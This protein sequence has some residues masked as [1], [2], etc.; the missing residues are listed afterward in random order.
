MVQCWWKPDTLHLL[1][2]VLFL[3]Y[4]T[5]ILVVKD[6]HFSHNYQPLNA[7]TR[8]VDTLL[9]WRLQHT[10]TFPVGKSTGV[11]D[12]STLSTSTEKFQKYNMRYERRSESIDF[13]QQNRSLGTSCNVAQSEC[14]SSEIQLLNW[15][16]QHGIHIHIMEHRTYVWIFNNSWFCLM[17]VRVLLRILSYVLSEPVSVSRRANLKLASSEPSSIPGKKEDGI[18]R[19]PASWDNCNKHLR[20]TGGTW[21]CETFRKA[22]NLHTIFKG[23][24]WNVGFDRDTDLKNNSA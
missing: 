9:T 6:W 19:L 5:K 10:L 23:L 7:S 11:G 4:Q 18:L 12:R 24:R 17:T 15:G 3:N 1:Q 20:D 2:T 16:L 13:D 22:K 8:M 21:N 14:A